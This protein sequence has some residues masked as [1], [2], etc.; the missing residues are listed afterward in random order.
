MVGHSVLFPYLILP[1]SKMQMMTLDFYTVFQNNMEKL[2][3]ILIKFPEIFQIHCPLFTEALD[4]GK[5]VSM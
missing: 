5:H 2:A 1:I 4:P 3:K